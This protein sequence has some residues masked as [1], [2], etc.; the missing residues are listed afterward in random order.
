VHVAALDL[1]A[2]CL[3]LRAVAQLRTAGSAD[4]QVAEDSSGCVDVLAARV[5]ALLEAEGVS[6]AWRRT[7]LV[8]IGVSLEMLD[9]AE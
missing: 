2:A 6:E 3:A 8:H 7:A 9:V 1:P 5:E 4:H